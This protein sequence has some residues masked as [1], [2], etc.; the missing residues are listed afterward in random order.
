MFPW[1]RQ[2]LASLSVIAVF[3]LLTLG[4]QMKESELAPAEVTVQLKWHHQAQFAGLYAAERNG[5]YAAEGLSVNFIE[6]GPEVDLTNSVLDG[7]A[8]FAVTGADTLIV[9]RAEGKPVVAIAVVYRRNPLVFFAMADSN[10]NGPQEFVGKRIQVSPFQRS[11]FSTMMA[12]VDVSPDQYTLVCCEFEPLS[13]GNF[14]P[15]SSGNFDVS[16][17][18][19]T[20]EVLAAEAAGYKLNIIYPEDY[21]V[22]LY[23]D[24]IVAS[25]DFITNRPDFVERCLR[26]TLKGWRWA[27]ENPE[28][29]GVLALNYDPTLNA[30]LQVAQMLAGIPLIHTGEDQIGWMRSHV[31]QRMIGWLPEQ[32]ILTESVEL[33]EVYTM[34][35]L[36]QIY[37]EGGL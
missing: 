22:H 20:N 17:G 2:I 28:E 15:L 8:Q 13:S 3:V 10:I 33:D 4:C 26:A 32:G 24:T 34:K 1:S 16:S 19:L 23:A 36:E 30:D 14:E 12:K 21:G 18:Y 25:D 6:G 27:V 5:Y 35:F 7:K 9:S 31:W 29:A 37:S 11:V